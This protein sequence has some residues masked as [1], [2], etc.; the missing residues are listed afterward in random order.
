MYDH[1]YE[2]DR[3]SVIQ[4][5]LLFTYWYEAPDDPKDTWHWM[6][7]ACSVA[8]SIGMNRDPR[9]S[10]LDPQRQRLWKRIWWSCVVRDR[11]IAIG[12]R[13]PIRIKE[14]EHDVPMLA[15]T[16]FSLTSIKTHLSTWG[17]ECKVTQSPDLRRSLALIFIQQAR[18]C[19]CIG[20]VIATQYSSPSSTM[21]EEGKAT[22][23][24]LLPKKQDPEAP[25][26]RKCNDELAEWVRDLPEEVQL[27]ALQEHAP[28]APRETAPL[29]LTRCLLHM[30]YY[31]TLSALHR[32]HAT[33]AGTIF[34]KQDADTG[35]PKT[36]EGHIRLAAFKITDILQHLHRNC[37][38]RYLPTT[39]VTV[40]QPAI[41][42]HLLDVNSENI[43][44]R[45]EGLRGFCECYQVLSR[46]R[47]IYPGA[48]YS[49]MIVDAAVKRAELDSSTWFGGEK[50]AAGR[51]TSAEGLVA[52][53][54]RMHAVAPVR[55]F[56]EDNN[57]NTYFRNTTRHDSPT[58]DGSD[59]TNSHSHSHT[60]SSPSTDATSL[61][62]ESSLARQLGM[63]LATT[64]PASEEEYKDYAP[65]VTTVRDLDR[66]F[67]NLINVDGLADA[68]TLG[69]GGLMS[70]QGE[71][72]GFMFD[73]DFVAG[74]GGL[75]G[76]G[77]RDA[78][79]MEEVC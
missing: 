16:D 64:P 29:I 36:P 68:L 54:L 6:G 57:D 37:C 51:I 20:N 32:P 15:L 18:L 56:N 75:G 10:N 50:T 66:D 19:H 77:E 49:I 78:L 52:T 67:E 24:K 39:G 33:S 65:C 47:D 41:I 71:S 23:M 55:R 30:V 13:R 59:G 21:S 79:Y 45:T 42:N 7:I 8:Q 72:S 70:M 14:D 26:I 61:D 27:P 44:I 3:I 31:M 25:E 58:S 62:N 5:L 43:Q 73:M 74:G 38:T 2:T 76:K 28:P 17:G 69:D 9:R 53:G 12:M 35:A 34:A 63:F 40:I 1:D 4:A 46:L 60:N 11:L 22:V 48:E